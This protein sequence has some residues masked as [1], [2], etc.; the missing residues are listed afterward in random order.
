MKSFK[1]LTEELI[2]EGGEMYP[3]DEMTMKE[4][5]VACY[6]AHNILDRLESGEHEC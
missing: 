1:K 3:A 6:A 5:K 2:N 4:V